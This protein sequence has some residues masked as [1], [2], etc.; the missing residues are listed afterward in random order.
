MTLKQ[1]ISDKDMRA[2]D[3]ASRTGLSFDTITRATKGDQLSASSLYAIAAALE[4]TVQT[5][6][7]AIAAS[8]KPK[9]VTDE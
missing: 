6:R 2:E 1:L 8:V 4:V 9:A 5:V 7:A 3:V